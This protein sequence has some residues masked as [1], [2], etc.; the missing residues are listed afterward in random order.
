M[1]PRRLASPR[2]RGSTT[3]KWRP[4]SVWTITSSGSNSLRRLNP[5]PLVVE[6]YRSAL[7]LND[8]PVY[9]PELA[10]EDVESDHWSV[11]LPIEFVPDP[12]PDR[13]PVELVDSYLAGQI[14]EAVVHYEHGNNETVWL[15]GRS[16]FA[17]PPG[18]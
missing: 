1:N 10:I 6:V 18:S 12:L 9:T 13:F 11:V 17:R 14:A 8:A 15:R 4:T 3:N 2:M 16:R 7:C 5:G